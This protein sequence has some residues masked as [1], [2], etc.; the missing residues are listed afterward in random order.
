MSKYLLNNVISSQNRRLTTSANNHRYV[1]LTDNNAS[2]FDREKAHDESL[3]EEQREENVK[4]VESLQLNASVRREKLDRLIERRNEKIKNDQD[5]M[6]RVKELQKQEEARQKR[7]EISFNLEKLKERQGER[8]SNDKDF[9]EYYKGWMKTTPMHVKIRESYEQDIL[10][11]RKEEREKILNEKRLKFGN[12]D[13]KEIEK[14]K[15]NY[16]TTQALKM[17][18]DK[19]IHFPGVNFEKTGAYFRTLKS[20]TEIKNANIEKKK[21]RLKLIEIKETY[22]QKVFQANK[23]EIERFVLVS[24]SPDQRKSREKES[25][26]PKIHYFEDKQKEAH[27]YMVKRNTL[28]NDYL[29]KF[30]EENA[31][32]IPMLNNLSKIKMDESQNPGYDGL[33]KQNLP[34]IGKNRIVK[35]TSDGNIIKNYNQN[36]QRERKGENSIKPSDWRKDKNFEGKKIKFTKKSSQKTIASSSLANFGKQSVN[37]T[38]NVQQNKYTKW[39]DKEDFA[40]SNIKNLDRETK[41]MEK[42]EKFGCV[43]QKAVTNSMIN[44][45]N[46]K[47]DLL[48]EYI[49][50]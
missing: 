6:V 42:M 25:V 33:N 16:M 50:M 2:N 27:D 9:K 31:K 17:M 29:L 43:T 5:K 23:K 15:Q 44:S 26:L 47:L 32:Q 24:R 46:C 12:M 4:L 37:D 8:A 14:H 36:R 7:Q 18:E 48:N 34:S 11:P 28:G 19:K 3:L 49:N 35:S 21:N 30:R 40:I 20:D 13:H 38:N 39:H 41:W 10:G 1:I 22:G 45:I